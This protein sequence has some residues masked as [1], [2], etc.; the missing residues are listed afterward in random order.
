MTTVGV[1][2]LQEGVNQHSVLGPWNILEEN[3]RSCKKESGWEL[4]VEW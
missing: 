4:V 2:P 3:D 1:Q